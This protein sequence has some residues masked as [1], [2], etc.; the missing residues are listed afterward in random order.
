MSSWRTRMPS[1]EEW[2]QALASPRLI[3]VES[4]TDLLEAVHQRNL[5]RDAK[6][7]ANGQ[8]IPARKNNLSVLNEFNP[9]KNLEVIPLH[10]L[11][12]LGVVTT[13]PVENLADICSTWAYF[14]Y[15]WAF[16]IPALGSAIPN[17]K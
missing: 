5:K 1:L 9:I 3:H 13:P 2:E 15:L 10:L 14:R 8:T 11:H 16:E 6:R 12:R 17:L 7:Q 4:S